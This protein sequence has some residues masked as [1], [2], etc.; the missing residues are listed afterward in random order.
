MGIY[1]HV[2]VVIEIVLKLERF[3]QAIF[4]KMLVMTSYREGE[5]ENSLIWPI[6]EH[7]AGQGMVFGLSTLNWAYNCMRTC[8]KQGMFF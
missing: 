4:T 6:Q 5:G 1:L 3:I 2:T 8:P 7:A